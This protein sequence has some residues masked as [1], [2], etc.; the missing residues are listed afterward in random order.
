MKLVPEDYDKQAGSNP[1]LEQFICFAF[2]FSTK[3]EGAASQGWSL[4][5]RLRSGGWE[6]V[7]WPGISG[8]GEQGGALGAF[9][10]CVGVHSFLIC[11]PSGSAAWQRFMCQRHDHPGSFEENIKQ[12]SRT[13]VGGG[14]GHQLPEWRKG[15]QL[16]TTPV[17]QGASW[18]FRPNPRCC[19]SPS[20]R[21]LWVTPP[22]WSL[23][24][25]PRPPLQV[26]L[27]W[28][29]LRVC[30][31]GSTGKNLSAL[32]SF[33]D[34]KNHSWVRISSPW[35]FHCCFCTSSPKNREDTEAYLVTK[36]AKWSKPYEVLG[37][38]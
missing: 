15:G 18:G 4:S 12:I 25:G 8:E 29:P 22:P 36:R 28:F 20:Q 26:R 17:V 32:P 9:P 7:R 19:Q 30:G 10:M 34:S 14:G 13:G 23:T 27:P 31:T 3:A 5:P 33:S 16:C 6:G 37:T 38:S 2:C 21:R 1:C 11:P 24:K 35:G